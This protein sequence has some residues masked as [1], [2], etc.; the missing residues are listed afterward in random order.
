MLL[1]LIGEQPIP[2]LLVSRALKAERNLL[3]FT[4]TTRR[5]ADNLQAMLPGASLHQVADY[6]LPQALDQIEALCT[7]QTVVN[8]TGGTKPM[9]L[10]AYE[11]A[12]KHGLA[13]VYLQSEGSAN[14]LYQYHFA[15]GRPVLHQRQELPSLIT[16]ADY[17]RAHGLQ[18]Q[19]KTGPQ[20]AQ[21]AGLRAWLEKQVDECLHNLVFEALEMDF[22]LRRGNRVAVVEAKMSKKNTRQG[23]DQLNTI[24]GRAYLGTYTGKV[25]I[26]GQP[27]GPQLVH[28]AAA[29]QIHVVVYHGA[30][31]PRTGRLVPDQ[32][33]RE[34]LL[35]A[36]DETLGPK[37]S[38]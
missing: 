10:A 5:V 25:W 11:V 35:N 15:N 9:A 16:I 31:D 27:L 7:P 38:R 34:A 36:L 29:R 37:S 4:P 8:L 23:I 33:T 3:A 19:F 20:N 32:P 22:I 12:R 18:P 30:E 14:V 6:D 17:L 21:E 2:N 24:A 1:S 13:V 26:V 28:L